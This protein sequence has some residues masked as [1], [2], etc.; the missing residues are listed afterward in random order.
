MTALLTLP[1]LGETME[2]GRVV[3][4]LKQPGEMFRRGETIVE[5]ES[6]KTVVELPALADGTLVEVLAPVGEDVAVGAP[7]CRY[8][9]TGAAPP[10]DDM[11][12]GMSA[13]AVAETI[14]APAAPATSPRPDTGRPRATPLARRLAAREGIGL[15]ALEGSGRRG[16]IEAR[17]V[18]AAIT[19]SAPD[20][21]AVR[22]WPAIGAQRRAVVL[23]HG[24]G[25]DAQTWAVLAT[26]LARQG[27][28]VSAPDLPSHGA[29]TLAAD[30]LDALA[31]PLA[32]LL[33]GDA[34]VELVG[35]SLGGAVA[36]LLARLHPERVARLTL[37]A[38]VGIGD[39]I[40][41][42]FVHGL[43]AVRGA[44]GLA[45]VLRRLSPHPLTLSP[46]QL[47]AMAERLAAGHLAALAEAT[48][49]GGRQQ[50]DILSVLAALPMPVRVV[51]GTAD[52]IIP[53]AQVRNLPP[54]I[55]I[56]LIAGAGHMP[57]WD[58]P[59]HIAALFDG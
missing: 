48:A 5:I 47:T 15:A 9:T 37:I 53:W 4:W 41:A 39:A 43:A 35:H 24:F 46:E 45:H 54:R 34:P 27:F 49:G 23:L 28:A 29:T 7:L 12:K 1:R 14:P 31:H 42:D 26:H 20:A 8:E 10:D 52:A 38:P 32:P 44:G 13:A 57:Q 50:I 17:D 16:R 33:A 59:Q 11:P 21:L 2:S 55:A 30:T 40:D 25:G 6:D 58:A 51:W 56:H 3:T 36:T 22:R 18:H 19:G